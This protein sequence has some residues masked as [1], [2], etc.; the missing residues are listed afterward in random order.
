MNNMK[1]NDKQNW[2]ISAGALAV[3]TMVVAVRAGAAGSEGVTVQG[4][5][6]HAEAVARAPLSA[7]GVSGA[8]LATMLDQSS[9]SAATHAAEVHGAGGVVT[10]DVLTPAV[11]VRSGLTDYAQ[12]S[13]PTVPPVYNVADGYRP[14]PGAYRYDQRHVVQND[15]QRS[16]G[17]NRPFT[18]LWALTYFSQDDRGLAVGNWL[19]VRTMRSVRQGA[20]YGTQFMVPAPAQTQTVMLTA[21][22]AFR[23]HTEAEVPFGKV[24][25]QWQN[26]PQFAQLVLREGPGAQEAALCWNY[27][28]AT[29]GRLVCQVWQVPEQWRPGQP[30]VDKGIYIDDDRE[31][32]EGESGH[33]YWRREAA[34]AE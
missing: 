30:L 24:L 28:L 21:H 27:A 9:G 15:N 5:V 4:P 3:L 32:Y 14:M 7:T 12:P 23:V 17:A 29:A 19:S 8:V 26:G 33:R 31:Y 25:Q 6:L 20:Q 13:N 22:S 18:D 1:R 11:D 10:H 2:M 16:A 34:R